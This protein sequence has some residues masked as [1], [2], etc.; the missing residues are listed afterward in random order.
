MGSAGM[1][2]PPKGSAGGGAGGAVTSGIGQF[3]ASL[4]EYTSKLETFTASLGKIETSI[5][6][7]GG[8][9]GG[10]G[11]AFTDASRKFD[12]FS[13]RLEA[14]GRTISESTQYTKTL[15]DNL[16]LLS[17]EVKEL[18]EVLSKGIGSQ[19]G[20]GT[21][22][23]RRQPDPQTQTSGGT[24]EPKQPQSLLP[25][26]AYHRSFDTPTTPYAI[27]SKET[28]DLKNAIVLLTTVIKDQSEQKLLPPPQEEQ[29]LLPAQK[30]LTDEK[31]YPIVPVEKGKSTATTPPT[32]PSKDD[33]GDGFFKG[34]GNTL[35]GV[36]GGVKELFMGI[37]D[38][39]KM[40]SGRQGQE[41][42]DYD[43]GQLSRRTLDYRST[44]LTPY[45]DQ[46]RH[47]GDK[48]GMTQNESFGFA[49]TAARFGQG[50]STGRGTSPGASTNDTL[51]EMEASAGTAFALG[52][53]RGN[54]QNTL[55]T[56]GKTG[57]VGGVS[58]NGVNSGGFAMDPKQFATIVGDSLA[59]G[60][61]MDRMDEVIQE[62]G[63]TAQ[64]ITA[65]GGI[66]NV[67]AIA[68]NMAITNRVAQNVGSAALQERAPALAQGLD[69]Y[70]SRSGNNALLLSQYQQAHPEMGGTE[71]L[72][73][74]NRAT[75]SGDP[76]VQQKLFNDVARLGLG[77]MDPAKL[78]AELKDRQL[79]AAKG[80]PEKRLSEEANNA[81]FLTRKLFGDQNF[82]ANDLEKM[83][84]AYDPANRDA[85]GGTLPKEQPKSEGFNRLKDTGKATAQ[86]ILGSATTNDFQTNL[87]A[88]DVSLQTQGNMLQGL[89]SPDEA[90]MQ[91]E[92]KAKYKA[93]VAKIQQRLQGRGV[94]GAYDKDETK[95]LQM[96]KEAYEK[97]LTETTALT[98]GN[99]NLNIGLGPN[100]L[101]RPET[102]HGEKTTTLA[103]FQSLQSQAQ[104]L[105]GVVQ[106]VTKFAQT[107]MGTDPETRTTAVNSINGESGQR[108]TA[109]E[110]LR[111]GVA[112]IATFGP[113]A[114][115]ALGGIVSMLEKILS[116]PILQLVTIASAAAVAAPALMSFLGVKPSGNS[117]KI[118]GNHP[119]TGKPPV[120]NPFDKG[121]GGPNDPMGG[122]TN[123]L[124]QGLSNLGVDFDAPLFGGNSGGPSTAVAPSNAL[125]PPAG[126]GGRQR[127]E[128][129]PPQNQSSGVMNFLENNSTAF[130]AIMHPIDTLKSNWF[131][132]AKTTGFA[133]Y[134]EATIASG[135]MQSVSGAVR[136]SWSSTAPLAEGSTV[137]TPSTVISNTTGVSNASGVPVTA[138]R[139]GVPG[140]P[141]RLVGGQF[142]GPGGSPIPLVAETVAVPTVAPGGAPPTSLA[143]RLAGRVASTVNS[144]SQKTTLAI[145]SSKWMGNFSGLLKKLGYVGAALQA[146]QLG[147]RYPGGM[148]AA[149]SKIVGAAEGF[150]FT[151]DSTFVKSGLESLVGPQ[152][153]SVNE[154]VNRDLASAG[155]GL[156]VGLAATQGTLMLGAFLA[157]FTG[158]VSAVVGAVA[159]PFVGMYAANQ[160]TAT[161]DNY[162]NGQYVQSDA[163]RGR[164]MPAQQTAPA[165]AVKAPVSLAP[166]GH[167]YAEQIKSQ[168][169]IIDA[170]KLYVLDPKSDAYR[171]ANPSRQQ[172]SVAATRAVES[173]GND[174]T[175]LKKLIEKPDTLQTD[176]AAE[177]ANLKRLK[178]VRD[179][180]PPTYTEEEISGFENRDKPGGFGAEIYSQQ[181]WT[182]QYREK[183][184]VASEA[185]LARLQTFQ[186]G[187]SG[188]PGTPGAVPLGNAAASGF[189]VIDALK[190]MRN[191]TLTA[192]KNDT[193][194]GGFVTLGVNAES[195]AP[196]APK[197]TLHNGLDVTARDKAT[198]IGFAAPES[199]T[200]ESVKDDDKD[201]LHRGRTITFRGDSG[202]LFTLAE[203]QVKDAPD[204]KPGQKL[205]QGTLLGKG[206]N[207]D[208][209][210]S[211]ANSTMHMQVNDKEGKN[212]TEQYMFAQNNQRLLEQ[213]ADV[214]GNQVA[215]IDTG[216]LSAMG[217]MFVSSLKSALIGLKFQMDATGTV[218]VVAGVS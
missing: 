100:G 146:L 4:G 93:G 162:M 128:N 37:V 213:G 206:D 3:T 193:T 92:I 161:Y 86:R 31:I 198:Q 97:L 50:A 79:R 20:D 98:G 134:G 88:T 165:V 122:P 208:P 94:E 57:A 171:T 52:A 110:A 69:S 72:N 10:I 119:Q 34:F 182:R 74:F 138:A 212:I 143:P 68:E 188:N 91:N 55:E 65:R 156:A 49:Q 155:V 42:F 187:A 200:I 154:W 67:T 204:F 64:T 89:L 196:N 167:S 173:A 104:I 211:G 144:L 137:I 125:P 136:S 1:G 186:T 207:W 18:K 216:S 160:A 218:T 159:A 127:S 157:P 142:S 178:E 150:G 113:A 192:D 25:A 48:T 35:S 23:S 107:L 81:L 205:T 209:A 80:E 109:A 191:T 176:I 71:L 14:H 106:E 197:G 202:N 77:G 123:F 83:I 145:Q 126:A 201:M 152:R 214:S 135:A 5:E 76:R 2:R 115:V 63:T 33:G 153:D 194:A 148:D 17:K 133:S 95:N 215:V 140:S 217:T 6:T 62:L 105:S 7:L 180:L 177:Q 174:I 124:E 30:L 51:R 168:Q 59:N 32:G 185:K 172:Q 120:G 203:M 85:A 108:G 199:G 130:N 44:E 12:D 149:V 129:R 29:K 111:L 210:K 121:G 16:L 87:E 116:L 166:Q 179:A 47:M 66:A 58:A 117:N 19:Q 102:V 26:P 141:T 39:I 78:Q 195:V 45:R 22:R 15:G 27:V 103:D 40:A 54:Y 151:V 11:T 41:K 82:S 139:P 9:L 184:I 183:D 181:A 114:A 147:L 24:V 118:V 21:T 53:S 61:L 101:E 169:A 36:A 28:S 46:I 90:R 190:N 8:R 170:N 131:D 96:G 163:A 158:G 70:V 60:R 189:V 175:Y 84:V 75:T 13:S 99:K 73:E 43:V 164:T 132:T 112:G 38:G 56:L